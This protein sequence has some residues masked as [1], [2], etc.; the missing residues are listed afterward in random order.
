MT[1]KQFLWT[2]RTVNKCIKSVSLKMNY[3]SKARDKLTSDSRPGLYVICL[4]ISDRF[5]LVVSFLIRLSNNNNNL[6]HRVSFCVS[7]YMATILLITFNVYKN[8]NG[9]FVML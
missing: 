2:T 1:T 5:F 6:T 7:Y 9:S 4:I 3:Y 8:F